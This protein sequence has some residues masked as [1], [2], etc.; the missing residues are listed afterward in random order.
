MKITVGLRIY[1]QTPLASTA[2][3]DG[4]ITADDNLLVPR[5]YIA[6]SL[7]HWLPERICKHLDFQ[8]LRAP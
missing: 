4:L 5:F 3:A 7:R 2:V 6:P 1:P 8:R